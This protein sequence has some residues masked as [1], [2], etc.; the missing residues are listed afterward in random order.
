MFYLSLQ[1]TFHHIRARACACIHTHTQCSSFV[2][3]GW[4]CYHYV[5]LIYPVPIKVSSKSMNIVSVFRNSINVVTM[6]A[7]MCNKKFFFNVCRSLKCDCLQITLVKVI[8]HAHLLA[9]CS[10]RL[11]CTCRYIHI[12][13]N[14]QISYSVTPKF[15]WFVFDI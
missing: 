1:L 7:L 11:I 3:Y 10:H 2:Q 4:S 14:E 6:M 15:N 5:G 8:F 9:V 13:K 12:T